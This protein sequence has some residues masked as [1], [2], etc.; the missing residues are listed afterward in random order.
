MPEEVLDQLDGEDLA[1]AQ[2]GS[3]RA[4]RRTPGWVARRLTS[5]VVAQLAMC[6]PPVT[7]RRSPL[8]QWRGSGGR[9]RARVLGSP[10]VSRA[11]GTSGSDHHCGR[12][13]RARPALRPT[14]S[15]TPALLD[16]RADDHIQD[17][18]APYRSDHVR[19]APLVRQRQI[20]LPP[21]FSAAHPPSVRSR[22]PG[23]MA[24]LGPRQRPPL[25]RRPRADQPR[26]SS[27]VTTAGTTA[28]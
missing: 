23:R 19:N 24:I 12:T 8:L 22:T 4:I 20:R 7:R 17:R 21:Q 28:T 16:T 2:R 3:A 14:A 13:G 10:R 5:I 11:A 27:L 6:R 1:P 15:S 18:P 26:A 9:V 25:G